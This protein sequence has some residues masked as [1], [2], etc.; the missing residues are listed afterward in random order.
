MLLWW[1]NKRRIVQVLG[2]SERTLRREL[3]RGT[4]DWVYYAKKAQ[5]YIDR[6]RRSNAIARVKLLQSNGYREI[7]ANRLEPWISSPDSIAG[8]MKMERKEFVCSKTIYNYIWLHDWWLK[9]LLTY[10]KRYRKRDSRQWKR[11][12]W[13]RHISERPEE[14]NERSEVWHTEIDLVMSKGNKAGV[15]TLVDRK[16]KLWLIIKVKSKHMDDINK[17]LCSMIRKEWIKKELKTITSDNGHEF[18]WLR[19][20]EKKLWF[21]QYYADPYSSRQRWT[22]EQY[23]WQIRKFF[24]KWTDFSKIALKKIQNIQTKLNRKPRK[25]LWYRTPEEVFYSR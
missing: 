9:G 8:R 6:W 18:F 25:I 19:Q 17:A 4:I 11:P 20:I 16:S 5:E 22:N 23:N 24:P 3:Q 15:M 14:A 7:L 12:E 2:C 13:Y 21:E 1:V 10:K